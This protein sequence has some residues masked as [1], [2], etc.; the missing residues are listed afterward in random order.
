[1]KMTDDLVWGRMKADRAIGIMTVIVLMALS[2][3]VVGCAGP[4]KQEAPRA[5]G[6]KQAA[7]PV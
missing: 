2:F 5:A 7:Q 6:G 3:T 4:K 1:M